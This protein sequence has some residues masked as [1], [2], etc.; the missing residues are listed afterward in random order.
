MYRIRKFNRTDADYEAIVQLLDI[1]Q[2]DRR[3][4]HSAAEMQQEDEEWPAEHFMLQLIVEMDTG[5]ATQVVAGGGCFQPYWQT[6]DGTIFAINYN[7]H[8][9]HS[10]QGIEKMIYDHIL[11]I[12][13]GRTPAPTKLMAQ[14][15]EDQTERTTFLA[16][17]GFAPVMRSPGSGTATGRF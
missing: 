3:P 16:A 6:Q 10:G 15:R 4:R 2:P 1:T 17:R 12:L 9:D 14:A 5:D 13:E 8:P 11:T 7:V